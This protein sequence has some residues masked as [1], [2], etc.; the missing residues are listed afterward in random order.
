MVGDASDNQ[1]LGRQG[2]DTYHAAGGNDSILANSGTPGPDPDPVIDCGEGFDTAQIDFPQN[3]PDAAPIGCE[4]I[5]EREPNSFRPPDTPPCPE[6][7]T[8]A[9]AAPPSPARADRTPPQ[10][11]SRR[12]RAPPHPRR[13]GQAE[14]RL[15][16]HAD[17]RATFV[18]RLDRRK[19]A[20]CSSPRAYRVGAGAHVFRVTATDAAGNSDPS[21]AVFRFRVRR[22]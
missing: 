14:G 12:P 11:R 17:E 21:P 8:R 2:A 10:T 13:V 22:R 3:G 15:P 18:C 1:L 16:V 4:A 19:P 7:P 5:H 9:A 6:P 20:P